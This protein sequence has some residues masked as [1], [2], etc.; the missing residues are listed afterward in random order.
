MAWPIN[1]F[2]NFFFDCNIIM[3]T[4]DFAIVGAGP[5]GLT[6]AYYLAKYKYR[7]LLIDSENEIGGCHRV[8]RVDGLFTEHGPRIIIR[9]YY[10]LIQL[11]NEWGIGFDDLYTPYDFS[12]NTSVVEMLRILSLREIGAFVKAFAQFMLT[13]NS[14]RTITMEQ[15]SRSNNFAPDS[16]AYVDKMCRLSD[17]GTIQNYTL[18]E[19]LQIFNQNFFYGIYQPKYPNDV[20]LFRIWS[21]QLD[22]T[23]HV[24]QMLGTQIKQVVY[25]DNT[26][27]LLTESGHTITASKCI[28]AIPPKPM[29]QILSQS[30]N[31]NI[32]GPIDRLTQWAT[33]SNY[34]V[35]VPIIFHWNQTLRLEKMWGVPESDYGIVYVI[36][37]DYMKFDDPRSKTVVVCTVKNTEQMSMFNG[38]TANECTQSELIVEVFRQLRL[39]RPKLPNPTYSILNPGVYKNASTG[40]WDTTDTAFFLTTS[41]YWSNRSPIHNNIYWVGTHNGHSTYSFTA[42][43][44]A[45]QNAIYLLNELV[46]ESRAHVKIRSPFT[47]KFFFWILI[48]IGLIAIVWLVYRK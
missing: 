6:L 3:S 36:M 27:S 14:S 48:L 31:P 12:T 13:E 20:G 11:L 18:F 29:V 17:G 37:S 1:Y 38:K 34:M 33:K 24:D 44:S 47:I 45:I 28:F 8:R 25:A 32:F 26:V 35:Y 15:F 2:F 30:P 23:G 4:H 39:H 46:P 5:A 43:E 10:A 21:D 40:K 22:R 9:N 42:M 19:F 41:G 7:V 16:V